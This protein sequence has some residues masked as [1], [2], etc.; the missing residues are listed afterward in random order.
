MKKFLLTLTVMAAMTGT[1]SAADLAAKPYTKAPPPPVPV[2]NWTGCYI[3]GSVG[4]GLYDNETNSRFRDPVTGTDFVA[5]ANV[6]VAGKGWLAGGGGG[7]DYQFGFGGGGGIFG[8]GQFVIGVLADYYWS[9]MRG[10]R[11]SILSPFF[12]AQEKVD[13]QWAV[14]G[15]IGWLVNPNTLTYF[16][17]GYTEA[18]LTGTGNFFTPINNTFLGTAIPGRTLQG[19]FLGGGVEYQSGWIPN[20]TWKTEY[21]VSEYNRTDRFERA[22]A[23]GLSTNFFSSDRLITQTVMTSLVY[24]FNWGGPVVAK[25]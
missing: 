6:D 21:R 25:Y 7:C 3:A 16:S 13:S 8:T 9:D 17:G 20:L 23:T 2:A 10:N 1:A 15:R 14:G 4:Y 12:S 5:G 11:P 18:H 22:I 19:W 24:R